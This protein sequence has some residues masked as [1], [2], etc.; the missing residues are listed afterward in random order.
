MLYLPPFSNR[1]LGEAARMKVGKAGK[2]L[3][4]EVYVVRS[5][6]GIPTDSPN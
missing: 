1:M 4:P 6:I 2:Q 5:R 3:S